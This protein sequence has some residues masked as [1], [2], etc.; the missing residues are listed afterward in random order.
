VHRIGQ[1]EFDKL[2][3][4]ER[5]DINFFIWGGVCKGAILS[6]QRWWAENG[7]PGLVKLYNRDNA[8]AVSLAEGMG[9]A[10]QAEERSASR[11]IKVASLAGAV[12]Q[13]K[14]RK[15]GQQDTLRYYWDH[16]TGLNIC[17]P[18][19]SNTRFQ[20]H[21]AACEIIILHMEL[22]LQFL[23]LCTGKQSIS[24]LEPHGTQCPARALVLVDSAQ[25]RRDCASQSKH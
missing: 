15:R 20:S 3:D 24:H 12:F 7:L 1:E 17:F 25:I 23:V 10:A 6:M 22:I 19:T 14:D 16:E 4:Q 11:A 2:S 13:H 5:Q 8:A 18:D 21:T 9:V